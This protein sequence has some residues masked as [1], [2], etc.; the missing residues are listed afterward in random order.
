MIVGALVPVLTGRSQLPTRREGL[1]GG[2]SCCMTVLRN[3]NLGPVKKFGLFLV[4]LIDYSG[5]LPSGP[6]KKKS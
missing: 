5:K 2:S 6:V 1:D 4:K 3:Y